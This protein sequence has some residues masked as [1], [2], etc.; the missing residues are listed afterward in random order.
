MKMAT[1]L[2]F[3][4]TLHYGIGGAIAAVLS[5]GAAAQWNPSQGDWGKDDPAHVRVMTWNVKDAIC[6][7]N[8]K[9]EAINAWT[10]C[11]VIIASM[12]PDILILQETGDNVG[13]GTGFG[14]DSVSSLAVAAEL[15]IHGGNDPVLGGTVGSYVQKYDPSFDLPHIFVS[16]SSDGFNRNIIMSRWPFA[17]LNGDG[18]TTMSDIPF[19]AGVDYAA[20]G[21]GGIRGFQ[22][23][24]IDLPNDV[25][26]GDLVMGGAHLKAGGSGSDVIQRREAAQNVAYF[27]DHFYNGAGTGMP[28]PDN[29]ISDN[30]PAMT[31]LGPNTPVIIGGDWNEDELT[32]G[33]KGPAEWLTRAQLTGGADG[34]DRDGSDAMFDSAV[35]PLTG[36]RGTFGNSSKLDYLGWQDSVASLAHAWVFN[37]ASVNSQ[38]A[39][40]EILSFPG[41]AG[42]LS[43]AASD[44]RPVIADFE[45][46]TVSPCPADLDGDG[47]V[48]GA[49]LASLLAS[50]NGSGS[51]DLNG[52]GVVDGA[53]LAAM[54]A[55]WGDCA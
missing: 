1:T 42:S 19:V 28:D 4:R 8:T 6:T 43:G 48:D 34:T 50:W 38:T 46:A 37:T 29:A 32:N 55:A 30:P 11:A 22:F 36:S 41:F 51:A 33:N 54:L 15:L 10:G 35:D 9:Q 14:Q 23:V 12:K 21:D 44:H 24:E 52:D 49:D 7:T 2:M 20:G 31:V 45:L 17:D 13:N 40:P 25:Y 3:S 26:A 18:R 27:I 5:T 16:S 47:V 39:P 53:D